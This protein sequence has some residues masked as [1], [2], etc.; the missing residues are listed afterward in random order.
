MFTNLNMLIELREKCGA[1]LKLPDKNMN[2]ICLEI[3]VSQCKKIDS[4]FREPDDTDKVRTIHLNFVRKC[5]QLL[6][7]YVSIEKIK[8][9]ENDWC[10]KKTHAARRKRKTNWLRIR[11]HHD[12]NQKQIIFWNV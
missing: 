10:K 11:Q 3:A 5:K 2:T 6:S 1:K 4:A 7:K 8:Q 9:H 12:Q